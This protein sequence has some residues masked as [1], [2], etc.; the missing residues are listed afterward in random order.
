[1]S[2]TKTTYSMIDGAPVNILDFGAP[3]DGTSDCYSAFVAAYASIPDTGGTIVFPFTT[4]N[5]WR[6][7]EG[8]VLNKPVRILGQLPTSSALVFNTGTVLEFAADKTGITINSATSEGANPSGTPAGNYCEITNLAVVSLGGTTGLLNGGTGVACD[9]ILN[10]GTGTI[11]NNV[12]AYFFRRN[13]MR[14]VASIG[15]GGATEGN[16]NLWYVSVLNCQF[17]GGDGLFV[18][19]DDVNAGLAL[20][21]NASNNEGFGIYDNSLLGNTYIGCHVD[22]NTLGSYKTDGAVASNT[23]IGCYSE[24]PQGVKGTASLIS[25]TIFIGGL[26]TDNSSVTTDSTAFVVGGGTTFRKPLNYQNNKGAVI[27]GSAVGANSTSMAAFTFGA[28]TESA[29][30]D[31]WK[32]KFDDTTN[33]WV[34]QSGGSIFFEPIRYLNSATTLYTLKGLTGPVFQ[35]GYGVRNASDSVGTAKVRLIDT[36]APVA[37]TYEIGDIVYNSAPTAGGFIGWVCTTAGTPG[38]W[39]TFGAISA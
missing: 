6:F 5:K 29:E 9:G 20:R 19:G 12:W 2:L 27:V 10:R 33:A 13:G 17:N 31:A 4:T 23:F 3:I 30:L 34:L 21:V 35:N 14:I 15:S 36:V 22:N 18:S 39:K 1:M 26:G 32:L 16:A 37:G 25:P 7:S 11:I 24:Q 38:T 8:I 28:S